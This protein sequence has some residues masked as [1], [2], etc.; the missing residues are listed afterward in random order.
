MWCKVICFLGKYVNILKTFC[1]LSVGSVMPSTHRL[2]HQHTGRTESDAVAVAP[3]RVKGCSSCLEPLSQTEK[4]AFHCNDCDFTV[5]QSCDK[6]KSHPVHPNHS[7]YYISPTSSW[8]CNVCKRKGGNASE[9]L[10]YHCEQCDFYLCKNCYTGVNT[11]LHPHT[12]YRTDVR[13]VYHQ[14]R[15]DWACDVCQKNNGPGH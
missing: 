14:S 6:P 3:A 5:C 10:C 11:L 9:T 8:R 1:F 4:P 2:H 7:L 12:L 15:G 13:Y